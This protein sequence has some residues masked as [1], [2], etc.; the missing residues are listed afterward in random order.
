[1]Q[2]NR[3]DGFMP[4]QARVACVDRWPPGRLRQTAKAAYDSLAQAGVIRPECITRDRS[5]AT[6]VRYASCIPQEW[7]REE[8]AKAE[9]IIRSGA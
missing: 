1:M 5:G 4:E 9:Q 2:L 3:C 8:L 7:A 6:Y